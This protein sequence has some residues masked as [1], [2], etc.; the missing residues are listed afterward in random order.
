M[1]KKSCHI[2]ISL[3]NSTTITRDKSQSKLIKF[4]TL[5]V[6]C[7]QYQNCTELDQT[8]KNIQTRN[9]GT[10]F[11]NCDN[12][13]GN[14]RTIPRRMSCSKVTQKRIKCELSSHLHTGTVLHIGFH[15]F[16]LLSLRGIGTGQF[17]CNEE[18]DFSLIHN[19]CN[20]YCFEQ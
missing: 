1:N 14:Y 16:S 17:L 9:H 19:T 13:K 12:V 3:K 5:L 2:S 11:K 6:K 15:V 4:R 20:R 10:I 8:F 7:V 18:T